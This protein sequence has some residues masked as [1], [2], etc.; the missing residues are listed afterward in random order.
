MG[1]REAVLSPEGYEIVYQGREKYRGSGGQHRSCVATKG[2]V[3][4][5]AFR[6]CHPDSPKHHERIQ[7]I[8]DSIPHMARMLKP[9][10]DVVLIEEA[11]G[12]NLWHMKTRPDLTRVE[13]QLIEFAR[14]TKRNGLIHGDLRPWNVFCD[15][16]QRVQ[17][18]DWWYLS[19]FIGD[20]V[21]DRPRR[22]DLVRGQDAHYAKFHPDLVSQNKF[23][24]IDLADAGIIGKLL[25]GEIELSD[26][27][28]WRGRYSSLG[29][30]LW[31]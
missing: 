15:D 6:I 17:V 13:G 18:I 14:A 29:R 12:E 4:Y 11:R 20:L 7:R 27:G 16:E 23:T 28:A 25:R 31:Q 3:R 30:F 22:P 26:A 10:K 5:F 8:Q 19:S 21:G 2:G 24:D 1:Y 9:I